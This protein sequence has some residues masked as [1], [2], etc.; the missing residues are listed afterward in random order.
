MFE[1]PDS[2]TCTKCGRMRP[3]DDFYRNASSR[4][5]RQSR[6]KDCHREAVRRYRAKLAEQ[7][8]ENPPDLDALK[9][10]GRCEEAK[11]GREFHRNRSTTDGLHWVCA[12]C[13]QHPPD[14]KVAYDAEKE[15]ERHYADYGLTLDD[16][17]QMFEDQDGRCAICDTP[18]DDDLVPHVDH[19]HETGRVRGLLCIRCNTGIGLLGDNEDRLAEAIRYLREPPATLREEPVRYAARPARAHGEEGSRSAHTGEVAGSNPAAPTLEA[20]PSRAGL[21][22]LKRRSISR[23]NV[24]LSTSP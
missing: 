14:R 19:C 11:P 12:E 9:E 2:K 7:N 17:Q 4:D 15:R 13:N 5:G 23:R 22:S 20:G 18:F 3:I 24:A 1:P 8:E 10:C 16:L 21:Y 6:C